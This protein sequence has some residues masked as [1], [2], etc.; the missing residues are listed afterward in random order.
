[1]G[2]VGKPY[3]GEGTF[4]E[5][6]TAAA[7][8]A[9]KRP[10]ALAPE[11]AAALPTAGGT[12]LAAIDALGATSGDPVAVIGAAGGVGSFA[13]QLGALRGF[14]VIAVTRAEHADYVRSLGAS[15]VIDYTTG[16]LTAQLQAKAP[17]GLAGIVDLFHDAQAL[18]ALAPAVREGGTI[19]TPS[20]MGVDQAFEGQRVTARLV[21]AATD[22]VAELG[23]LAATGR[24]KVE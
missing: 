23:D 4:A 2:A 13:V 15:D 18:L 10:A 19:A 16:N 8:L 24:L 7:A 22:R 5:Y 3:F 11:V 6:V 21:R 14:R 12:G 1:F 20:A 17:A 9:A